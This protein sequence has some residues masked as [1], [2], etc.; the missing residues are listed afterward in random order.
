MDMSLSMGRA[1]VDPRVPTGLASVTLTVSV[2]TSR[3]L[4]GGFVSASWHHRLPAAESRG[5]EAP[6]Q[7][8]ESWEHRSVTQE[9]AGTQLEEWVTLVLPS[10]A[11]GQHRVR[12]HLTMGDGEGGVN[13]A[14]DEAWVELLVPESPRGPAAC[15][16]LVAP[17]GALCTPEGFRPLPAPESQEA[18]ADA[19]RGERGDGGAQAGEAGAGSPHEAGAAAHTEHMKPDVTADHGHD[20]ARADVL[21]AAPPSTGRG[22]PLALPAGGA[23]SV[24]VTSSAAPR[25]RLPAASSTRT[26]GRSALV[27]RG[28]RRRGRWHRRWTRGVQGGLRAADAACPISTG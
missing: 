27:P 6:A 2:R 1:E 12:V 8:A 16:G 10:L 7:E 4:R 25:A 24:T 19:A 13:G 9:L 18:R 15:Q 14:L 3:P 5:G 26:C 21:K 17:E 22:A 11:A 20:A 23:R 28:T